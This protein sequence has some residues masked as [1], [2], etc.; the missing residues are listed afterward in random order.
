MEKN[1]NIQQNYFLFL[2]KKDQTSKTKKI[3]N[4]SYL[5]MVVI[6]MRPLIFFVLSRYAELHFPL[7]LVLHFHIFK[8]K[9]QFV[10]T[11]QMVCHMI[12]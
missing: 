3:T 5:K 1:I 7:F 6:K 11:S 9:L 12:S 2:L 4:I 8:T 10:A